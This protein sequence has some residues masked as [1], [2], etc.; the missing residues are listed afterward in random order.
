MKRKLIIILTILAL[1]IPTSATAV[2]I[3]SVIGSAVGGVGMLAQAA[4]EITPGEEHYI[5]RAVAAILLTKYPL[6][7]NAALTKYVNEVGLTL[8]HASDRPTTYGGYHFAVLN[9]NDPNAYACPGGLI[10]ISK[11]LLKEMKNED[12]LA[13]VLGHEVA[14]VVNRDGINT[15]KKS[16][17][18]KLGFYAAGEISKHASPADV[19]QLVGVFQGVVTDVA[20]KVIDSGYSKSDEKK[21]DLAGMR[22]ASAVG[23]NPAAMINF[24]RED[25]AKG[26]GHSAGPFA[27][28]PKHSIRIKGLEKELHGLD[29]SGAATEK[30]RTARFKRT[31]NFTQ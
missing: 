13:A 3:G 12:Q 27:S 7:N 29:Q 30:T 1:T 22:Y 24:F 2:D 5:G 23:Y 25:E 4:K 10:F 9:S 21:A 16:R 31:V 20:K 11:A 14:H 28:H 18:T 6:L 26:R 17:W 8:A 19:Q 15:I